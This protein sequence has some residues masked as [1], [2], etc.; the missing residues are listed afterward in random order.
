[1]LKQKINI[2]RRNSVC[3]YLRRLIIKPLYILHIFSLILDSFFTVAKY[4]VN[5]IQKWYNL[6]KLQNE[7]AR[8]MST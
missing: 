1:M 2:D 3:F 6:V 8:T 4:D 5:F 7:T